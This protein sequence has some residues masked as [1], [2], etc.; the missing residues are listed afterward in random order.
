MRSA[1]AGVTLAELARMCSGPEAGASACAVMCTTSG[2]R[3]MG[4][5]FGKQHAS[6]C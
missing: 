1:L 4:L 3:A 5:S 2:Q 6:V